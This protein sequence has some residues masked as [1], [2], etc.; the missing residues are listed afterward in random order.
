MRA[1]T[2]A[3]AAVLVVGAGACGDSSHGTQDS[4]VEPANQQDNRAPHIINMPDG[5]MNLAFKCN[6]KD[7]VYAHTRDAAPVVIPN[8]PNCGVG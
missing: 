7:G 1:R 5:F 3:L 4:P 8:D 2:L 6:G